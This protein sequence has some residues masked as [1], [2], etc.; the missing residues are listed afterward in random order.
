ME[1]MTNNDMY[2][3]AGIVSGAITFLL[4]LVL[5][6]LRK[7]YQQYQRTVWVLLGPSAQLHYST[8]EVKRCWEHSISAENAARHI[9]WAAMHQRKRSTDIP[10]SEK[11]LPEHLR[12]QAD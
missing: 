5:A 9:A 12:K 6:A 10:T 7:Q 3:F 8:R 1:T 11:D 2:L 4:I